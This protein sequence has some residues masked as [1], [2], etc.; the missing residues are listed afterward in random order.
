MDSTEKVKF[1]MKN[2]KQ[3]DEIT[4]LKGILIAI[5]FISHFTC[6]FYNAVQTGLAEQSHYPVELLVA[7]T[8]FSF[9]I[10]GSMAVFV[11]MCISGFLLSYHFYQSYDK[12]QIALLGIKKYLKFIGP[13]FLSMFIGVAGR[14]TGVLGSEAVSP[15]LEIITKSTF[16]KQFNGELKVFVFLKALFFDTYFVGLNAYSP[17]LWFM[18]WEFLG[19]ILTIMFLAAFGKSKGRYVM[20]LISGI[21]IF[22]YAPNYLTFLFGSLIGD[23][24]VNRKKLLPEIM[25]VLSIE[26]GILGGGYSAGHMPATGIYSK[27]PPNCFGA[28]TR[29]LCYCISSCLIVFAVVNSNYICRFFKL[30]LFRFL[31][32]HSLYILIIHQAILFIC[33]N[34]LFLKLYNWNHNYNANAFSIFLITTI[35]TITL[36]KLLYTYFEPYWNRA[37]KKSIFYWMERMTQ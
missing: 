9:F 10:N 11:F 4:G 24:F 14:M 35:I 20:Y 32:E 21:F 25:C 16:L 33:T 1:E 37:V 31:G 15:E 34:L 2:T 17:V 27:I 7:R 26:L 22:R 18:K 30:A 12:N 28:D 29:T 8:P 3:L 5:V 19:S 23:F 6:I 13:I 36:S